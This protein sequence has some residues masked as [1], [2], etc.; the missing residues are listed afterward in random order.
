M[1]RRD[2][3]F[4]DVVFSSDIF[5]VDMPGFAVKR[6]LTTE[7]SIMPGCL[8]IY[9]VNLL[10]MPKPFARPFFALMTP[11]EPLNGYRLEQVY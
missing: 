5:I 9:R 11:N 8:G 1:V 7:A 6:R 2:N 3:L 4:D 10:G